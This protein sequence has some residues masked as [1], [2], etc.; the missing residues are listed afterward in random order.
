MKRRYNTASPDRYILLKEHAKRLKQYTTDAERILWEY[1]NNKQLGVKF[2]RQH[3]IGDYIVDFVCLEKQLVIEVD[4]KYHYE[5][6]QTE[7]DGLRT[8]ELYAMGFQVIRFDNEEILTDIDSVID[9]IY[10]VIEQ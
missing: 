10:D 5:D 9:R 2:N 1:L 7:A 6:E 4:G 8:E 3:I